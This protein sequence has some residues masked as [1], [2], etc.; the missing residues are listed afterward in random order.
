MNLRVCSSVLVVLTGC[1]VGPLTDVFD[2]G[3]AARDAG[4]DRRDTGP[5]DGGSGSPV[6]AGRDAGA[7]PPRDGGVR[8]GGAFPFSSNFD[9]RPEGVVGSFVVHA[10]AVCR[11]DSTQRRFGQQGCDFVGPNPELVST[12]AGGAIVL[13]SSGA[14]QIDGELVVEGDHP[15]LFAIYGDARVAGT[16]FAGAIGVEDGPGANPA[17]CGEGEPGESAQAGA[18]GGGFGSDGASGGTSGA[19]RGGDGGD[20][21]GNDALVPLRGG[22]RG[23][24]VR[25]RAEGG[26]G[27]GGVQISALGCLEVHGRILAPGGGGAAQT[28]GGGAGGGSGGGILLEAADIALEPGARIVANGGGGGGASISG[29]SESGEDGLDDD[30][31][32]AGGPS[33][34]AGSGGD[35]AALGSFA[36]DG[37]ASVVGGGGGGGGAGRIRI[38]GL[39][40]S[41][42]RD[43]V[44]SPD[45][46]DDC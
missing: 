43:A 40:C 34:G 38:N 10:G 30:Q 31:P 32:A 41:G 8:D 12:P 45:P 20:D 33:V 21:N 17:A 3:A 2:A 37:E 1:N 27:G 11:F 46:D 6:D 22:C 39:R 44:I 16:I 25:D 29:G 18:G 42:L 9:P 24:R 36:Q 7:P 19:R 5:R 26:G 15:V 13:V 35:G 14:M 4:A 28:P 23:G